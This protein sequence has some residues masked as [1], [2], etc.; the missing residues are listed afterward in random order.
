MVGLGV[1]GWI[2]T[3]ATPAST[4]TATATATSTSTST[5]TSTSTSAISVDE[6]TA[7]PATTPD[8]AQA[9]RDVDRAI[10]R[11]RCM[12]AGRI[13]AK[14]EHELGKD[15]SKRIL[16]KADACLQ[17]RTD[18]MRTP[19]D[20]AAEPWIVAEIAELREQGL[21]KDANT[22][23]S[24]FYLGHMIDACT[25]GDAAAAR[26]AAAKVAGGPLKDN[27]ITYC[28]GKKIVIE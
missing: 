24:G 27:A 28:K 13:A 18:V 19:S 1:G 7:P 12:E 11:H 17:K 5:A 22:L 20:P 3:R 21:A 14:A 6:P 16:Q 8:A 25:N 10:E 15:R 26:K 9:E 4:A 23:E 2:A